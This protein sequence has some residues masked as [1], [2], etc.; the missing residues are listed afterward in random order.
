MI[1]FAFG[2]FSMKR[3]KDCDIEAFYVW[4]KDVLI[5]WK[6]TAYNEWGTHVTPLSWQR[7]EEFCT[8]IYIITY[9]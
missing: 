9:T 5:L 7:P 8:H 1:R 2:L 4:K 6:F 3:V